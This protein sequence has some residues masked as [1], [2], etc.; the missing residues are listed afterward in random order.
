MGY[1]DF[2][3]SWYGDNY[4]DRT[5][6]EKLN[7]MSID[8]DTFHEMINAKLEPL[9]KQIESEFQQTEEYK[10]KKEKEAILMAHREAEVAFEKE[11]GE[12]EYKY[13][14]DVFGTLRNPDYPYLQP[15]F[16]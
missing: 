5:L 16:K 1:Y 7:E 11:Y 8:E 2:I 9:A 3:D 4:I 10:V 15:I 6:K 14:Y 12:G 13:C